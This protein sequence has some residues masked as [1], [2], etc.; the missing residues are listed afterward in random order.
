MNRGAVDVDC[1]GMKER[2]ERRVEVNEMSSNIVRATA[3]THAGVDALSELVSAVGV[4]R[5]DRSGE[6]VCSE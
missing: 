4:A 1:C 6:S 3:L 2:M 5:E